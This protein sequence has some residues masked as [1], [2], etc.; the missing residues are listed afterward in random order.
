M[1]KE[2]L[3]LELTVTVWILVGKFRMILDDRYR[4]RIFFGIESKLLS[5]FIDIFEERVDLGFLALQK[6][7]RFIP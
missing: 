2:Q 6:M 4:K 3:E 7:R 1:K 5:S